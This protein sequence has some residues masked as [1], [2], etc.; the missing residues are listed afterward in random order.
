MHFWETRITRPRDHLNAVI[1]FPYRCRSPL[2]PEARDWRAWE[3]LC[4]KLKRGELE[5]PNDCL[6]IGRP[7]PNTCRLLHLPIPTPSGEPAFTGE[8]R[9][10]SKPNP[11]LKTGRRPGAEPP[12][13]GGGPLAPWGRQHRAAGPGPCPS[14]GAEPPRPPPQPGPGR[15]RSAP[16]R[17]GRGER[18]GR[19]GQGRHGCLREGSAGLRT[20]PWGAGRFFCSKGGK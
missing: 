4:S 13:G 10:G 19:G 8:P 3:Q 1:S 11:W 7:Q 17:P 12:G 5:P 18:G 14:R 15:R 2:C 20:A 16:V 6:L 9:G